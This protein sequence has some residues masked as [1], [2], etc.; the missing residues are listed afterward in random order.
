MAEKARLKR[1]AG[2]S[3]MEN[4]YIRIN[5]AGYAAGLPVRA[6]VLTEG[7]LTLEKED[8]TI[9]RTLESV[10]LKTDEASQDR[11]AM[12]DLGPLPAGRYTLR[13]G[14][15]H[16][17]FTVRPGAWWEVGNALIKG[18]YYQRCGCTLEEKYA[19]P[20][21]HPACHMNLASSMNYDPGEK[22]KFLLREHRQL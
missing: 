21:A 20:Y 3:L 8:G 12:V 11:M 18:L 15:S 4:A 9:L 1:K 16:R 22:R 17:E 10:R 7:P 14:E 13:C 5:Q 19:G 6:A 2:E